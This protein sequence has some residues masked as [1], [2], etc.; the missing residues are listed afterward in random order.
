MILISH[1]SNAVRSYKRTSSEQE[2]VVSNILY[3]QPGECKKLKKEDNTEDLLTIEKSEK[4]RTTL[5]IE[6]SNKEQK[7]VDDLKAKN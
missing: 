1:K 6:S 4:I 3:G 2:I 7:K 5:E